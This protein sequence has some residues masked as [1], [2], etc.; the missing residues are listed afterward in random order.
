MEPYLASRHDFTATSM[1][2]DLHYDNTQEKMCKFVRLTV[3]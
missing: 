3:D 1:E 2:K